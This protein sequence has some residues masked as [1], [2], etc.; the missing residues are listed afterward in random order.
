MTGSS[1]ESL[2]DSLADV[3][4][5]Q[6]ALI[7]DLQARLDR[8]ESTGSSANANRLRTASHSVQTSNDMVVDPPSR[9]GFLRLAGAAAAGAAVAAVGSASPAAALDGG[10]FTGAET[11]FTNN[12]T[13]STKAGVKGSFTGTPIMNTP[14]GIGVLGQADGVPGQPSHPSNASAAGVIGTSSSGYGVYGTSATGYA[15]YAASN[16][17]LGFDPHLAGTAAPTTGGYKLGDIVMNANGDT[18][19]CVAAGSGG[20]AKFR[21]LAGPNTGGQIHFFNQP[22]RFIASFYGTRMPGG[23][24]GP[25][26]GKV[27]VTLAG[28]AEPGATIPSDAVAVFG[29]LQVASAA[30]PSGYAS[31]FAADAPA[32]TEL[33]V[34]NVVLPYAGPFITSFFVCK[35]STGGVAPV[36]SLVIYHSVMASVYVD[37]AGYYR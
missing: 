21:K 7:A 4:R 2:A 25:F 6:A 15:L 12:G 13:D 10:S 16:G 14:G 34:S 9:R 31:I 33:Q 28:Q 37:I 19:S 18:F 23:T 3:V 32:G 24:P 35:L 20:S 26:Q 17:R 11:V 5:G 8:L 1:D 30:A 27:T 36:G 22:A 29:S